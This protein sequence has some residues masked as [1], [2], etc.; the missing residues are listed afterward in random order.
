MPFL[1]PLRIISLFALFNCRTHSFTDNQRITLSAAEQKDTEI[2][3]LFPL[4]Y[5][6]IEPSKILQALVNLYKLT[7]PYGCATTFA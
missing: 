2:Q 6:I 1:V 7:A 4:L 3:S 5:A